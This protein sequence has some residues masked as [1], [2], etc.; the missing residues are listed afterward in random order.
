VHATLPAALTMHGEHR[1]DKLWVNSDNQAGKDRA[2][3]EDLYPYTGRFE[4]YFVQQEN[5][6]NM[7]TPDAFNNLY[8]LYSRTTKITWA[9]KKKGNKIITWLPDQVRLC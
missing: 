5:G 4:G 7:L 8:E 1:G 9:N 6:G 3:V 2:V